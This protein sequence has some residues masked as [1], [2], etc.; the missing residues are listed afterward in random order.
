MDS[1]D[2][3]EIADNIANRLANLAWMGE[4]L[5]YRATDAW[6]YRS[7][8]TEAAHVARIAAVEAALLDPAAS[9]VAAL[10][11]EIDAD[12]LAAEGGE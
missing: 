8:A 7:I 11:A 5:I 3:L 6:L 12:V 1:W 10:L 4:Q 9:D 2:G